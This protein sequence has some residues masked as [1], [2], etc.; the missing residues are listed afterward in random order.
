MKVFVI[1]L[2]AAL[3]PLKAASDEVRPGIMRTPDSRF[4]SLKDFDF[5]P[6]YMNIQGL[7]IHYLD[8]GPEDGQP[9]FLLHGQ[10]TWG[11]L[12]RYMIPPLADAGYRVIVPDM[13][14]FGRSD[15]PTKK[16]DYSY[17]KHIGINPVLH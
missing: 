15:K 1:A 4:E 16:E 10:P 17:P 12:F 9:I 14:G 5:E 13:A 11:Y 3:I 6:N 8:E 2:I 7:R